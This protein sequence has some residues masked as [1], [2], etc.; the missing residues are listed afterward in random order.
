MSVA[1][2]A[3]RTA[4]VQVQ[5]ADALLGAFLSRGGAED[6]VTPLSVRMGGAG[7]GVRSAGVRSAHRPAAQ[8]IRVAGDD[9]G[10]RILTAGA[11]PLD[12]PRATGMNMAS[13]PCRAVGPITLRRR[14]YA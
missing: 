14:P 12:D 2:P 13:A 4:P 8:V 5:R 9:L 7:D 3:T 10:A 11:D 6:L 1:S